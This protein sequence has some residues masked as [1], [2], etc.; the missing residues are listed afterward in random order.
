MLRQIERKATKWTDHKERSFA[1]NY[2][3]E[4]LI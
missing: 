4:T 2:F 1:T 3:I